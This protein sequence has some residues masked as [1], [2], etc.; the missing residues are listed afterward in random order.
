MP[1][2]KPKRDYR[3][4]SLEQFRKFVSIVGYDGAYVAV[5]AVE[6]GRDARGVMRAL[7]PYLERRFTARGS[8]AVGAGS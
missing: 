6:E 8:A 4:V 7:Q 2:K 1:T 5:C 3:G